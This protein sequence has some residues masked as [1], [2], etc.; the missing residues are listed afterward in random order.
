MRNSSFLRHMLGL[1]AVVASL[2]LMPFQA[3]ADNEPVGTAFTYQG[4]LTQAG[5]PV[6]GT[7]N[8]VFR[9][10]EVPIGGS[11]LPGA[12]LV[13]NDFPMGEDGVFTIDLDFGDLFTGASRWLEVDVNGTTLNPRQPIMPAPYAMVATTAANVPTK[14]MIGSYTGITGVGTLE[15]LDVSGKVGIGASAEPWMQMRVLNNASAHGTMGL[16]VETTGTSNANW[17]MQGLSYGLNGTGIEGANINSSGAGQGVYGIA[18]S[19]LGIGVHGYVSSMTGAT[20]GGYFRV[21][22][23]SGR[24]VHG[25]ATAS[26]GATRGVWGEV[27]SSDGHAAYF[28]GPSGSSNYFQRPVGIGITDPA[29]T[30]HVSGQ[31]RASSN[32]WVIRGDRLQ[33]TG[34]FPGVW[35]TTESASSGTAGVRG[36]A[37]HTAPGATAA[38]VL[39]LS[40]S[41]T[42]NGI[43]VR[44]VHSAGGIGV[45]GRSASGTGVRGISDSASGYGGV[46]G[47]LSASG[48]GILVASQ[49]HLLDRVGVGTAAPNSQLHV[50]VAAGTNPLRVQRAGAT[51]LLVHDNGN[52]MIGSASTPQD[53]LHVA[54]TTRTNVLRI[55]GGSDLAER[56][57]VA[58][59][60]DLTPQP[61]MVVCMDPANPGKL[62]PSTRTYDRTVA[63]VIS[64]ANG[65][66]SGMIMGQEGSEADGAYPVALTG[67][68]YVY[69]DAT[70][71]AIE[72]GDLLTTSDTPG[73]AMRVNDYGRAQGAIIGK[74]M[75]P[76]AAGERG[77][78][79]VLVSLQ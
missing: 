1:C 25:H 33:Q 21:A 70:S 35:G 46:F 76:L 34:T 38:G 2:N 74:A 69:T 66:N 13:A 26:S 29:H 4:R 10:Y 59:L 30:L 16:S 37:N 14:A 41:T 9:L 40:S 61:G 51:R 7:V 22:S 78:V 36:D 28:T 45:E 57:D 58:D 19:P 75:T 79:L 62:I 77:M 49:S 48:R 54:G 39:G 8:L 60:E 12:V 31:I 5:E 15:T 63:G 47:D 56:F 72:V 32:S 20:R 27:N 67:R 44:G 50:N 55:M 64:G 52:I 17:A 43:G 71:G 42:S 3:L 65:I 73:H 11:P 68:V 23:T 53:T 6:G 24:G 18:G